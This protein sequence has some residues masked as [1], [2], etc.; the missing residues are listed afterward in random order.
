MDISPI[1]SFMAEGSE[2]RFEFHEKYKSGSLPIPLFSKLIGKNVFE[3]WWGLFYSTDFG[4]YCCAGNHAERDAALTLINEKKPF[5]IIVDPISLCTLHALGV[6]DRLREHYG[7]IGVVQ[8]TLDSINV[9][10]LELSLNQPSGFMGVAD[11]RTHGPGKFFFVETTEEEHQATISFFQSVIDWANDTNNCVTVEAVGDAPET[12]HEILELFDGPFLD[13]LLAA[14]SSGRLI[15]TD[16]MAFR[17]VAQEIFDVSCTWTQATLLHLSGQ[18]LL[19]SGAYSK[20]VENLFTHRFNF[21]TI[22]GDVL[23][24]IAKRNSWRIG[25][26]LGTILQSLAGPKIDIVSSINVMCHVLA[27]LDSESFSKRKKSGFV[28]FVLEAYENNFAPVLGNLI[29]IF[30]ARMR[31]VG[32]SKI[33]EILADWASSKEIHFERVRDG[34]VGQPA[35]QR[36]SRRLLN[37]TAIS[38]F[39]QS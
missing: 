27:A 24:R 9:Y 17:T 23:L 18:G 31:A 38:L 10:I 15:V 7:P 39:I 4:F 14:Q 11:P 5:G 13:T 34:A 1:L 35:I 32:A 6:A 3:V 8:S 25:G 30:L 20:L 33:A 28:S 16:D 21:T 36:T 12:S 2:T 22:N 26:T 37:T 29:L 19:S